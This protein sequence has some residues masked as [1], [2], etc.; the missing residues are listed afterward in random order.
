MRQEKKGTSTGHRTGA[1]MTTKLFSVTQLARRK[2]QQVFVSLIHLLDV[3]FL[4]ECFC[5]LNRGKSTGIDGITVEDYRKDLEKNL[6]EL[7]IKLKGM[8]FQP[9]AVKRGYIPK[10]DGGKRPI[11]IAIVEDKIVQCGLARILGAIFEV[12]FLDVSFGF[13]PNRSGKQGLEA[14]SGVL[15]S[16]PINIVV[17]VDIEK[18]FDSIDHEWMMK[19]LQ[20]RIKDSRMLRLIKRFLKA[21]I[22]EEGEFSQVER[23]TTQGSL[24]SPIL[25]NI[26]LHYVLDLWFERK[27]KQENQGFS[28]LFRYADDFVVCFQHK[29]EAREFSQCLKERMAKFGLK[30]SEKKSRIIEFGRYVW[31]KAQREGKQMETF[32][33]LGFTFYG[34]KSKLGKFRAGRKTSQ[35]KFRQ[36]LKVMNQWLKGIRNRV[37]L[38]DWWEM[39][40]KKL[41]GHFQYYDLIGNL[42]MVTKFLK[43]TIK[44]AFKWINRRSQKNSF[45]WSKFNRFLKF[46]PLPK[47]KVYPPFSGRQLELRMCY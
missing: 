10:G 38:E 15:M 41:N 31:Q 17:D 1:R 18:F 47:P 32:D 28:Q 6:K 12:N 9:T 45:N 29:D 2:P 36:K 4:R 35:V 16:E 33:F 40:R 37:K 5:G 26:Y 22:M 44:L 24:L 27:I 7:V 25:A 39:L 30:L 34:A 14:L 3:N 20:Q 8:I 11:G 42:G 43:E 13:R 23:G 21:G 19:F 46:N